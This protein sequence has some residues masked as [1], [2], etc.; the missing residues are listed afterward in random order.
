M[1]DTLSAVKEYVVLM[2][3]HRVEDCIVF[4]TSA[5][6]EAD[7][8]QEFL[9]SVTSSTGVQVRVLSGDEEAELTLRGVINFLGEPHGAYLIVDIGG[10][11][12]EFILSCDGEARYKKSIAFGVVKL[13]EEFLPS[14]PIQKRELNALNE[15]L[16]REISK[17]ADEVRPIHALHDIRLAGT[18]GTITTLAAID[19]SLDKYRRD[20]VHLHILNLQRLKD[21]FSLLTSLTL[22]ERKLI[23]GL[24]E[25]RADI[26]IPGA[27]FV[28]LILEKFHKRK[29]IVSDSGILEGA[30]ITLI[31]SK[32]SGFNAEKIIPNQE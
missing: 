23:R 7:N 15:K 26:I 14:D 30:M 22:G 2:K 4:G 17:V 18:A 31:S 13:F 25:G 6:R 24:E 28:I 29:L 32:I 10:G 11:S 3:S 8:A 1:E 19:L 16:E 20:K 27:A 21:I 9:T 12:T 5:L